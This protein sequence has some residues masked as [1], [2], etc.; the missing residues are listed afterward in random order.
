M[1][2]L[3]KQN[4][5]WINNEFWTAAEEP[6]DEEMDK[7]YMRLMDYENTGLIPTEITRLTA[8]NEVLKSEQLALAMCA[9]ARAI[10]N[11]RRYDG[12]TYSYGVF[13]G[14]KTISFYE[15]VGLLRET[16]VKLLEEATNANTAD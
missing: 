12:A 1:D 2:R 10:E 14:D 8:E 16:G 3:T 11:N 15:A 13:S 7:V 5:S 6:D 4:P 9:G